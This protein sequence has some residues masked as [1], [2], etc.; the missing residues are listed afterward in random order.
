MVQGLH[1]WLKW[2]QGGCEITDYLREPQVGWA[3]RRWRLEKGKVAYTGGEDQ[4]PRRTNSRS[5]KTQG[6][7]ILS[8]P[9]NTH[10][11]PYLICLYVCMP[12]NVVM[13]VF[14]STHIQVYLHTEAR[15]PHQAPSSITSPTYL[16]H[17]S[18]WVGAQW[19]MR[20]STLESLLS[21]LPA[22]PLVAGL[23][24]SWL[25]TWARGLDSKLHCVAGTVPTKPSLQLVFIYSWDKV[26]LM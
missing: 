13:H 17:G 23:T 22:F 11:F 14:M 26:S 9:V 15:G 1:K 2:R 24:N 21:L 20:L 16:G 10:I 3:S 25:F 12:I 6:N 19:V 5:Q 8:H 18:H 7:K 4:E